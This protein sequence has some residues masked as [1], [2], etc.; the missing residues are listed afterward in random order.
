MKD[1]EVKSRSLRFND[2]RSQHSETCYRHEDSCQWRELH[3]QREFIIDFLRDAKISTIDGVSRKWISWIL[4]DQSLFML[5]NK[6]DSQHNLQLVV[7]FLSIECSLFHYEPHRLHIEVLQCVCR[8]EVLET[9][10]NRGALILPSLFLIIK[11]NWRGL[12]GVVSVSHHY[13]D[14]P[15]SGLIAIHSGCHDTTAAASVIV[16]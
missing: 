12:K 13:L 16:V 6:Y 11:D 3:L 2:Q 7:S 4:E 10:W 8:R 14:C 5:T 15:L 9:I 1:S